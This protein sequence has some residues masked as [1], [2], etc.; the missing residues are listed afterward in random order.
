MPRSGLSSITGLIPTTGGLRGAQRRADPRHAGDG[1]DA[2]NRVAR[3]EEHDV[4]VGDGVE[5]PGGRLSLA[6]HLGKAVR[7]QSG[8]VADPPFLKVDGLALAVG[9][10]GLVDEDV[11][12]VPVIGHRQQSDARLPAPTQR[13]GDV[14]EAVAGVEHLRTQQVGG[15]IAVAEAKPVGVGA[16]GG[17]LFLGVPGLVRASPAALGVDAAAQG[18]HAGIEVRAD[19]NAVHPG[20]VAHVDEGGDLVRVAL[21]GAVTVVEGVDRRERCG[22]KDL[23]DALQKTGAADASNKYRDL[24]SDHPTARPETAGPSAAVERPAGP[25]PKWATRRLGSTDRRGSRENFVGGATSEFP[26]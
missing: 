8:A 7:R 4:G 23:A 3:C 15:Q 24:H 9:A 20:V 14:R 1:A 16:V 12:L 25:S 26:R 18:V 19:P 13:G 5:H 6:V 17:Q 21:G 2:D 22:A 11:S 10:V